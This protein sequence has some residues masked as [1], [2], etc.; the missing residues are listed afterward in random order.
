[1]CEFDFFFSMNLYNISKY[2]T[3][4]R[5]EKVRNKLKACLLHKFRKNN[6]RVMKH[7]YLINV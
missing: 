3:F 6:H 4:F 2:F 5:N 7:L 1:M